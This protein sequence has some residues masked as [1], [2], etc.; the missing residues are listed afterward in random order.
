MWNYVLCTGCG[1]VI[2]DTEPCSCVFDAVGTLDA[3]GHLHTAP[4]I[5]VPN[6]VETQH[7]LLHT[8]PDE[9]DEHP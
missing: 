3:Q 2:E 6:A 5:S 8:V 7:G 1:E 4:R 9:Y